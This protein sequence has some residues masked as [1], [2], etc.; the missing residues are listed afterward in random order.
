MNR[1]NNYFYHIFNKFVIEIIL[2]HILSNLSHVFEF[3][4]LTYQYENDIISELN[5]TNRCTSITTGN[6]YG[7]K[8]WINQSQYLSH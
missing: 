2:Y 5:D 1:W 7:G 4:C 3:D 6:D 8:D